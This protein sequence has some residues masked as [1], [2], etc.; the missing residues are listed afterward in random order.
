M[1][2]HLYLYKYIIVVDEIDS[3]DSEWVWIYA[4]L[5]KI[6]AILRQG[7]PQPAFQQ[8]THFWNW[9]WANSMVSE[10]FI[11]MATSQHDEHK[12]GKWWS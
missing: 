10:R 5:N 6:L 4:T 7:T 12:T 2:L 9:S 1:W 3:W 11:Y 8:F